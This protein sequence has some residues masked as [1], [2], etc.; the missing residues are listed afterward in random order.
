VSGLRL[1]YLALSLG[2]GAFGGVW[3]GLGLA[4]RTGAPP[5]WLRALAWAGLVLAA[6][7]LVAVVVLENRAARPWWAG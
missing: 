5:P 7:G 1:A 2:L 3:M 6:A 4:R